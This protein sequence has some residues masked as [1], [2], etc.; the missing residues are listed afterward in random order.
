MDVRRKPLEFQEEDHMFLKITP[1][2]GIGRAIKVKKLSPH[3]IGP[4][5]I[6]KRTRLVPF[7]IALPLH[8][9]NLHNVFHVS[10]LR[11]YHPDPTHFLEPESI[12]LRDDLTFQVPLARIVDKSNKQLHNKTVHLVKIAGGTAG[13]EDYTWELESDIRRVHPELFLGTK[14]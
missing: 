1:M 4:F 14:F 7:Q 11:K 6:L 9:S 10:Q 13:A 5:Q 8:L 2:T 3:F 12:Q